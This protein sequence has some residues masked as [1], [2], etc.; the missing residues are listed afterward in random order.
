MQLVSAR[1][2]NF[3][4]FSDSGEVPIDKVTALIAENENGKTTF[5]R[6]LA[7]WSDKTADFDEEDR[8]EGAERETVLDLVALTFRVNSASSNA[9]RKAGIGKPPDTITIIRSSDGEYRLCSSN[10]KNKLLTADPL[11]LPQ[12]TLPGQSEQTKPVDNTSKSP[13]QIAPFT[14]SVSWLSLLKSIG[15]ASFTLTN[16]SV[17]TGPPIA[18]EVVEPYLPELIYFDERVD[19]V[20]DSITYAEVKADPTRHRTM[21]N[22]ATIAGIDLVEVANANAHMRQQYSRN[23][24]KKFRKNSAN[25]GRVIQLRYLHK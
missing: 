9:L 18:F 13:L 23:A 20:Q 21:I 10:M 8:W 2:M 25:I 17:A 5:L 3:G 11:G 24:E 6:A 16:P 19:F 22:L 7:W 4:C 15:E 14:Q 1:V 12:K